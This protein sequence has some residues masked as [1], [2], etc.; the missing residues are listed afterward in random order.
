[1]L[2]LDHKT[3]CIDLEYIEG[4]VYEIVQ[5]NNICAWTSKELMCVQRW[6]RIWF[7]RRSFKIVWL[8]STSRK[9][10][11]GTLWAS[12]EK[13][14]RTPNDTKWVYA[15]NFW[16]YM[17]VICYIINEASTTTSSLTTMEN[18]QDNLE[19]KLE[20]PPDIVT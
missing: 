18:W 4:F 19:H 13:N 5:D 20:Y 16:I 8:L 9:C 7:E 2:G 12:L 11:Y 15:Y 14:Q 3:W 10:W 6:L 17:K 1:M